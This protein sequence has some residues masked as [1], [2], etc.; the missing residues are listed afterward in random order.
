MK[1][2][3]FAMIAALALAPVALAQ[4]PTTPKPDDKT[5][6]PSKTSAAGR[7]GME[8]K[9]KLSADDVKIV[10]HLHHLNLMEIDLGKAAQKSSNASVKSYGDTLVTDHGSA[11]KDLMAFAKAH[12]LNMIPAEKPQTDAERQEKKEMAAAMARVK[13]LRGAEFDREFLNMALTDHEK[14][15][16]KIDT[17]IGSASNPDLQALLRDY[18]PVLQR[19]ADQARNL[20]KEFE[21]SSSPPGQQMPPGGQPQGDQPPQGRESQPPQPQPPQPQPPRS[22]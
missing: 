10:A 11:D 5:S 20:Q 19:H 7:G 22:N 14:E 18:K 12:K 2:R 4:T 8:G 9:A 21:S 6:A 3:S 16:T 15:L 17:A 13:A 1:I